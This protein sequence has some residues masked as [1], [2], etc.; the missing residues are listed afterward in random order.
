MLID[1]RGKLFGKVNIIDILIILILIAGIAMAGLKFFKSK[2]VTPFTRLD[3]IRTEIFC[4]EV[5]EY[6]GKEIKPGD[7]IKDP[8]KNAE[9]GHVKDVKLKDSVSYGTDSSGKWVVSP[10][11]GYVS[12]YLVVEGK[13]VY[14]DGKAKSGITF[15]NSEYWIGRQIELRAGNG[16]L[17]GRISK[18]SK[19]D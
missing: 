16:A 7:V 2:T 11:P 10:K 18:F 1:N 13:G 9:I 8:I 15:D 6:A 19:L 14:N 12:V 3:D 5:P 17:L 4:E